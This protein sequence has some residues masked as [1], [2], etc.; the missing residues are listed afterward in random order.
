MLTTL[1]TI[2]KTWKSSFSRWL[3]RQNVVHLCNDIVVSTKKKWLSSHQKTWR[4]L[5][6]ALL[7]ERSQCEKVTDCMRS[8]MWHSRKG[9]TME[10]V[11]RFPKG[12]KNNCQCLVS[13]KG[14][15]RKNTEDLRPHW[16]IHLSKP[17]ESTI[18][19]VSHNINCGLWVMM[20]ACR[21]ICGDKGTT[22]AREVCSGVGYAH[23][24]ACL[25]GKSLV[26]SPQFCC[27]LNLL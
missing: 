1:F 15:N 9:K 25:Y 7:D 3:N 22:L 2:T 17:T 27:E 11:E 5:K 26:H 14:K 8:I 23:V 19:R 10:T 12:S 16:W 4:N 20:H 21:F 24:G 18:P 6:C 13:E